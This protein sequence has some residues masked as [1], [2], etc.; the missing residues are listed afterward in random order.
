[1]DL[2]RFCEGL[3]EDFRVAILGSH[4]IS[5]ET[6]GVPAEVRVDEKPLRYVLS[7]LLS[8]AIKY[9]PAGGVIQLRV[10]CRGDVGQFEVEDHG[11][12]IPPEDLPRLFQS[13][14]RASNVG[15]I[16]G[17][18]LGLCIAKRMVEVQGGRIEVDSEV[19]RGT[20]VR[21]A[22]PLGLRAEQEAPVDAS[23][24]GGP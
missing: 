2:S 5:F 19:S 13:F 8:N 21:V 24:G 11:I 6:E 15:S 3:V 10:R 23:L 20:T 17:T 22:V 7:N 16:K 9:S 1:M 18:G 14:H 12:G 4:T